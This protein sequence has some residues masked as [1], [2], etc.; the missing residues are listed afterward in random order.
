MEIWEPKP[1]GTLWA[2]AGLLRDCFTFT[3]TWLFDVKT[4]TRSCELIKL[5]TTITQTATVALQHLKGRD[6]A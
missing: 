5:H 3:F 6:V 4:R 2:T 1:P